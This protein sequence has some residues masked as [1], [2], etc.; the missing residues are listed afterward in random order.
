MALTPSR[1]TVTA[2]TVYLPIRPSPPCKPS[3][4][5]CNVLADNLSVPRPEKLEKILLRVQQARA[6]IMAE[7][8]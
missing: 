4:R 5:S 3:L 8:M 7:M 1:K 6:T 2:W